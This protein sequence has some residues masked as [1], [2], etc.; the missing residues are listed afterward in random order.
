MRLAYL[1]KCEAYEIELKASGASS[2]KTVKAAKELQ[3]A[4][5]GYRM[6]VQRLEEYRLKL[7][8]I[9]ERANSLGAQA[10]QDR[11]ESV[12][13]ALTKYGEIENKVSQSRQDETNAMSLFVECIK[14]EVD[15]AT[16]AVEFI[17]AWPD[18]V[19]TCYENYKVK[20]PIPDLIFGV[21]LDT[22]MKRHTGESIPPLVE[23]CIGVLEQ[24]GLEVEGIHRINGRAND[25][26]ILRLQLELDLNTIDWSKFEP[27]TISTVLKA[28]F[29]ELPEPLFL[30]PLK[31][32]IEY[33]CN[34]LS[35]LNAFKIIN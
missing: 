27:H 6:G 8:K 1:K 26:E 5:H 32:R 11:I 28:Y 4:D 24:R 10:E 29:K 25:V 31:D 16:Y 3:A 19:K 22:V 18:P 35:C 21:S 33:S 20:T 7:I 9:R 13:T 2:P 17:S 23:I 14:P 12:R 15:L 34:F 30:F